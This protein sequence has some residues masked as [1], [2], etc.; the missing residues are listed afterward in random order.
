MREVPSLTGLRGAAAIWVMLYH[1]TTFAPRFGA[2][3]IAQIPGLT[4]GWMGVDLF[5]VLSGFILMR[6]HAEDFRRISVEATAQFAKARLARV[7]PL[8]LAVLGLIVLVAWSDPSFVDW[9]RTRNPDNFSPMAFVR[10]ALLATRWGTPGGDWNQPVWSLSV[11]MV[12]YSAFPLLAWGMSGRSFG[13]AVL[14][15]ATSLL[16]LALHQAANGL[17]GLNLIGQ[18]EAILRMGFCFKIGRAHV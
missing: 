14:A 9:A 11:E 7:Y 3:W 8:S 16:G 2:T 18:D 4:W 1:V 10:T 6:T 5:F 13:F 15:A 12:G 17:I